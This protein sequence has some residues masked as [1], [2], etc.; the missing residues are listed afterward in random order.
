MNIGKITQYYK[1]LIA[2]TQ[3]Q[4]QT[5]SKNKSKNKRKYKYNRKI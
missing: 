3:N 5:K 1:K 2:T 4:T